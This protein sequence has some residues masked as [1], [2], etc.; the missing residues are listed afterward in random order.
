MS[1]PTDD[2]FDRLPRPEERTGTWQ[3]PG[4]FLFSGLPAYWLRGQA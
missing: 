1:V 3:G 4:P 2:E